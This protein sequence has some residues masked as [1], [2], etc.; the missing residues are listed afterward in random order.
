[1]KITFLGA[2]QQVTGSMHLV[3]LQSGYNI[4]IDCGMDYELKRNPT[5]KED[6][7]PFNPADIDALILT[8]AHIDHS[9]NIPSLV[10]QGFK[11]S[12]ICTAATAELTEYL[13]YDSANIQLMEYRKAL[14][15]AKK[16]KRNN[17]PKPLYMA[18]QVKDSVNQFVTANFNKPFTIN[19]EVK[20]TLIEAGHLLGAASVK[21]EVQE[22][23]VTKTIGF[24]GDLGRSNSKLINDATILSGIDTLVS[25]CTYG[26]RK[27]KV[28]LSAED[29]MLH[30]ITT[31]CIDIRG[32]LV[33]PAFS[34]GRTQSIVF[35]IIKLK[36]QGLI[37]HVKIFV[38][39][40]LAIRSTDVY[41]KHK[42]LLNPEAFEFQQKFGS[43]LEHEDVEYLTDYK[44][45]EALMYYTDPSVIIS[46]AGMVEGGRIQEH[47]MN[48]I[49]NPFSTILISGFCAEGTFGH[50]LLNG[51]STIHIKNKVKRV[52]A[53]I[54][55]TD[56]F[57][58][59]PDCDE[60]FNYINHTHENG[61]KNVFLVHGDLTQM[62]AMR[63]RLGKENIKAEMPYQGQSFEL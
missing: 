48:N 55:S 59:H 1:M 45:H 49:E 27:H 53:K 51:Q 33:I 29:E 13:L 4:L 41:E 18:S 3:T 54:A 43:L 36:R 61:C 22:N 24:T 35:T 31:T 50:K 39:S 21:M 25:E 7:F 19:N 57:S 37:P 44:H 52:F 63:D 12:I 15:N 2:A 16:T 56:I 6:I 9:G 20:I 23:G 11:G 34:V 46:A 28:T 32:R 47:I 42:E 30:Y 58:S 10:Y 17:V 8:H 5:F 14:G 60:I 26:G 40:P 38:D 62:T